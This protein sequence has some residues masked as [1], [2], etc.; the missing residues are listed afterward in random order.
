MPF[1]SD[2]SGNGLPMPKERPPSPN[3]D[4][5]PEAIEDNPDDYLFAL[6]ARPLPPGWTWDGFRK[7]SKFS[8]L[9]AMNAE[10]GIS[11]ER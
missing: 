4:Q 9:V 8:L 6:V 1:H 10:F 2:G 11:T 3:G 7:V 5:P